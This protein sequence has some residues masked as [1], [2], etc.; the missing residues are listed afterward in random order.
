MDATMG[1]KEKI[2]Q[3]I[4]S[5]T[6]L[7][8]EI[9][10]RRATLQKISQ[11]LRKLE[12][13]RQRM[14]RDGSPLMKSSLSGLDLKALKAR[15]DEEYQKLE[16]P[17]S[18]FRRKTLNIG[19]LGYARQGKS[20]FLRSVSKLG[21][22]VIPTGSEGA[23]TGARSLIIHDDD[24]RREG[25]AISFYTE[26]EF[27]EE[28][29]A[30]YYQILPLNG[31]R[32]YSIDEFEQS[33]LPD[34]LDVTAFDTGEL[35]NGH[36]SLADMYR[37]GKQVLQGIYTELLTYYKHIRD[38]RHLLDRL[39]EKLPITQVRSYIAQQDSKGN[40]LYNY[41]AVKEAIIRKNFGNLDVQ[42]VGMLHIPGLGGLRIADQQRFVRALEEDIDIVLFFN[43]PS[44]DG[45]DIGGADL[46]LYDL[47]R[48]TFEGLS[49]KESAFAVVNRRASK[50]DPL[51]DNVKNCRRIQ[52]QIDT[53]QIVQA[54]YI[55]DCSSSEDTKK[56]VFVP[57]LEYLKTHMTRYHNTQVS[58]LDRTYML[59]WDE[60]YEQLKK[61]V[62]AVVTSV[63]SVSPSVNFNAV[64]DEMYKD[65]F[66]TLWIDLASALEG[67]LKSL[68]EQGSSTN[69]KFAQFFRQKIELCR[70]DTGIR[71]IEQIRNE[72]SAGREVRYAKIFSDEIRSE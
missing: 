18:R 41:L 46:A 66:R 10:S 34:T 22:D 57:I 44:P 35:S 12:E 1:T 17:E 58:Q 47:V 69:N 19:V 60:R 15:V 27:L 13:Q 31:Y 36:Q 61:D 65:Y 33:G 50:S 39:V 70:S 26:R 14:A 8:V 7:L 38:Y 49:L 56:E 62:L 30:P 28:V 45:A 3:I 25:A 55:V 24:P 59:F 21:E 53:L 4:A 63:T 16:R 23:C 29:L 52:A 64:E 32:P 37:G 72:G 9:Q 42:Q 67:L 51:A 71:S 11:T 43:K 20:T 6:P 68:R 40:P 48:T 2:A 54:C 5:R